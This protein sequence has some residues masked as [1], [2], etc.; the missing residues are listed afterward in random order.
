VQFSPKRP[1]YV[2]F[3]VGDGFSQIKCR[4][5]GLRRGAARLFCREIRLLRG[6][7]RLF[8]A[9]IRLLR[10]A[11]R[12]FW[13]KT[14]LLCGAGRLF[15]SATRLR[16]SETS[17][18]TTGRP[19]KAGAGRHRCEFGERK[20][21]RGP[22]C[23]VRQFTFGGSTS[24]RPAAGLCGRPSPPSGRPFLL[25]ERIPLAVGG[26]WGAVWS[27]SPVGEQPRWPAQK[28][29]PQVMAEAPG[30]S[31]RLG[32]NWC[33]VS[34]AQ[35]GRCRASGIIAAASFKNMSPGRIR[36]YL[37]ARYPSTAASCLRSTSQSA[38]K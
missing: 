6:A 12:L 35:V 1:F 21:E 34:G 5:I 10:R 3:A 17:V 14:R 15:C 38:T 20:L 7:A 19:V 23:G 29:G 22:V 11:T 36:W 25:A 31:R 9:A 28:R 4:K 16:R 13:G 2:A 27:W 33:D 37:L 18:R 24:A 8:C 30:T 32:R 26:A